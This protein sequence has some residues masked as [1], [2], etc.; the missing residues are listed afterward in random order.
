MLLLVGLH[1]KLLIAFHTVVSAEYITR[2]IAIN[3]YHT[4]NYASVVLG[5]II[6]SV[7]L[8]VRH[9]SHACFVTKPNNTL[10]IF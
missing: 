3:L 4:I 2:V 9:L 5:V 1:I 10:R 8:S 7:C 6:L